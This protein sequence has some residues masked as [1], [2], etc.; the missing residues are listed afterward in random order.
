MKQ[1]SGVADTAV[2]FSRTRSHGSMTGFVVATRLVNCLRLDGGA[3][4]ER[5]AFRVR[6]VAAGI[7]GRPH[8]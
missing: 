5:C 6:S 2:R 8:R 1:Y 4:D 7:V 3:S